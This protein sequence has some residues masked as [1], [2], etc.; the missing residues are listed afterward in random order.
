MRRSNSTP[1]RRREYRGLAAA[2]WGIC[3]EYA[4]SERIS[5][6]TGVSPA[7]IEAA[8]RMTTGAVTGLIYRGG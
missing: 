2:I 4:S 6:A 3:P 1:H 7:F 8:G 5:P